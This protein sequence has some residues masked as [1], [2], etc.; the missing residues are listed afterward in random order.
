VHQSLVFVGAK[1]KGSTFLGDGFH[2]GFNKSRPSNNL[3]KNYA[4]HQGFVEGASW[5][6]KS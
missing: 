6:L 2:Q 1:P 5:E 4:E 3:E